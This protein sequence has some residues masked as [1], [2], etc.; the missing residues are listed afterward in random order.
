MSGPL[1]PTAPDTGDLPSM[2]NKPLDFQSIG[3]IDGDYIMI[4]RDARVDRV[5][6]ALDLMHEVG[7]DDYDPLASVG[8]VVEAMRRHLA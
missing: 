4:P 3:L 5:K 6:F 1:T 8:E 7:E 2:K